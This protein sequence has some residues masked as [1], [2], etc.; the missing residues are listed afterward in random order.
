MLDYLTEP[1][2]DRVNYQ[3]FIEQPF[4]AFLRQAVHISD[5]FNEC[6][7]HFPKKIND[8]YTKDALHSMQEIASPLLASLMSNI[9]LFQRCL[10][11]KLFDLTYFIPDFKPKNLAQALKNAEVEVGVLHLVS[12]RGNPTAAGGIIADAMTGWHDPLR[13]NGYFKVLLNIEP[14]YPEDVVQEISIL[15]QMR[16]SIVHTGGTF[17]VPDAQKLEALNGLGGKAVVLRPLAINSLVIRFHKILCQVHQGFYPK[18]KSRFK[19]GYEGDVK[20]QIDELFHL[21]SPRKAWLTA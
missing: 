4:Y 8:E 17:T 15:W 20:K 14:F 16:H 19:T 10:Y 9:E 13:V 2:A 11:A 12:Y 21:D 3:D 1:V 6:L 7:R 18:V 5:A